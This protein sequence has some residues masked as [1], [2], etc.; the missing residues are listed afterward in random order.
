MLG[1]VPHLHTNPTYRLTAFN[2]KGVL[3]GNFS[4]NLRILKFIMRT[5]ALIEVAYFTASH[6]FFPVYFFNAL[7]IYEDELNSLFVINQLKLIGAMVL[8]IAIITWV[9]ASDPLKYRDIIQAL[10]FMGSVVVA[11]FIYDVTLKVPVQFI[12]NAVLIGS[13]VFIVSFLYPWKNVK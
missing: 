4:Q 8:G 11:I 13:Q 3:V 5:S 6:W 10:L 9:A 7:G 2:K 1:F 12:V